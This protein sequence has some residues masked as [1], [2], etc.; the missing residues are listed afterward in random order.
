ME[1]GTTLLC[2]PVVFPDLGGPRI[3]TR[4]GTEMLATFW[5]R[6]YSGVF[7]NSFMAVDDE[8]K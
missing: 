8:R 5:V 7:R 2:L 3:A 6:K 1:L 4:T